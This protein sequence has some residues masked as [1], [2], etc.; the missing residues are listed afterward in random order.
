MRRESGADSLCSINLLKRI[1]RRL[2]DGKALSLVGK[3]NLL[4]L[5]D[6]QIPGVI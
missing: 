4:R 5:S 6:W 2:S 3:R 1:R